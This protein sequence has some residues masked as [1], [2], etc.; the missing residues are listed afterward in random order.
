MTPAKGGEGLK[1]SAKVKVVEARAEEEDEEEEK[2]EETVGPVCGMKKGSKG[3]EREMQKTKKTKKAKGKEDSGMDTLDEGEGEE[4]EGEMEVEGQGGSTKVEPLDALCNEAILG[5][6]WINL[7]ELP[8]LIVFGKYNKHP[9]VEVKAR[10]FAV[11]IGGMNVQPFVWANMLPL[12]ISKDDVEKECIQLKPN[13]EKAPFL[14]LKV[15]LAVR[16]DY[17]LKFV[18]GQHRYWAMEI[19]KEKSEEIVR[20]LKDKLVEVENGLKKLEGQGKRHA[21]ALEKIEELK[22]SV[23]VEQEVAATVSVWGVVLYDEGERPYILL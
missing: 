3:K 21:N 13:V 11:N 22:N 19:L 14:K 18:G 12:V 17:G 8:V 20:M 9:L 7:F 5:Y 4:D 15:D 2:V 23:K 10:S 1:A 6:C 16:P